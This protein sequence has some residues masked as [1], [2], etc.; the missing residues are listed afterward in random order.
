[1]AC[2]MVKMVQIV[3]NVSSLSDTCLT[4]SDG[5]GCLYGH[6][7]SDGENGTDSM[8]SSLP[9]PCLTVSDK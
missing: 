8:R 9:D 7:W 3:R 1:M 5:V 6:G 2:Q 4:V